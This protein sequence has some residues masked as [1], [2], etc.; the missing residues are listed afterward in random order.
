MATFASGDCQCREQDRYEKEERTG[1]QKKNSQAW[2]AGIRKEAAEEK[3]QG[4]QYTGADQAPRCDFLI[5]LRP[6]IDTRQGPT[7]G[8]VH[9]SRQRSVRMG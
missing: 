6:V 8:K 4:H 3:A 9:Q 7:E 2:I 1:W 5:G